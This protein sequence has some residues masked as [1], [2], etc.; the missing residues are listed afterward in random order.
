MER[1]TR[2]G[3]DDYLKGAAR[4]SEEAE[5]QDE[6]TA[7]TLQRLAAVFRLRARGLEPCEICPLRTA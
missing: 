3:Y 4:C 2:I 7:R 6:K 1:R 5:R